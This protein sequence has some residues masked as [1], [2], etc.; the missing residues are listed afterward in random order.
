MTPLS[1]PVYV[2]L[3]SIGNLLVVE[4]AGGCVSVFDAATGQ[5]KMSFGQ[6]GS[7]DGQLKSPIGLVVTTEG[8][9]LVADGS[10]HRV[11]MFDAQGNWAGSFGRRGK[12]LGEM[13]SPS[14]LAIDLWGNIAVCES[15]RVQIF[16][17]TFKPLRVIGTGI[18]GGQFFEP[19]DVA[20][21]RSGNLAVSDTQ[22]VQVFAPDGTLIMK[23]G[24]VSQ[25]AGLAFDL[26]G[27]LFV[28]EWRSHRFKMFG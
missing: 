4:R 3:D 11:A 19:W 12:A 9:R 27:N 20:Y 28:S 14:G 16:S 13:E 26:E 25:P 17:S 8:L 10:N 21:D 6:P 22:W 18:E 15:F 5:F 1:D 7:G 24:A 2:V 23:I